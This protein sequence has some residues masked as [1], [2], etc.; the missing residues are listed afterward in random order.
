MSLQQE[1][2]AWVIRLTSGT[3]T[4]SDASALMRWRTQSAEHESAYNEAVRM[5]R[6]LRQ[7]GVQY[8]R[9]QLA[10]APT[11]R[12]DRRAFVFGGVAAAVS[13][14]AVR[15]PWHL[16]PSVT[17]T[18]ADIT[19]DYST[20][21]GKQRQ[22]EL[23]SGVSIN[24]NT[25]TRINKLTAR[26]FENSAIE[27]ATGEAIVNASLP[28]NN[29]FRIHVSGLDA[30]FSTAEVNVRC[31]DTRATVTCLSGQMQI[32][33]GGGRTLQ[34]MARQQVAYNS[35]DLKFDHVREIDP[36]F[37]SAWRSGL[38]I[39]RDQPLREVIDEINRY[40][41]GKVLLAN[42]ALAE[43]HVSGTFH[44]DQVDEALENI[45]KSYGVVAKSFPAR[46]VI[47]T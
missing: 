21:V 9:N 14:L 41:P 26:K 31:D 43:R 22:V 7:A 2:Q 23:Q 10:R 42:A 1:A 40:R 15:P 47:L 34:L 29:Q 35:S 13:V 6:N 17:E 25:R 8:R 46:I 33:H 5:W 36:V 11:P 24:M 20:D 18:Y 38:L 3:A 16:W 27:L 37:V 4:D 32:E 45:V 39:F 19:A 12:M 28:N 44:L 30:V